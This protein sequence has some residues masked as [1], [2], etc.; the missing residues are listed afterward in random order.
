MM[1]HTI[2]GILRPA[3]PPKDNLSKEQRK[4]LKE[5]RSLENE[6]ILPADKGNATLMM[7]RDDYD[8]KMRGILSTATYKQLK[9]DPTATQEG[10]LSR[11]LKELEKKGEISGGLYHRLRPSVSQPPR[12]YGLPKT[13]KD[14]IPIRPIVCCIGAPSYQLS[15]HI[16]S[17]ISPLAGKTA[18]HVKNSRH[19]VQV[20]ADL[21]IE[22]DETLVSFDV[23]SLFTNVPVDEAVR[24]IRDRLR[25]DEALADRTTLST[26]RVADLLEMC[27]KSTYFSYGGEFFEQREGA[28][29]GSSVSAVVADLYMEFFEELALRTAPMKPRLWKRYVDDTCCIVKK[30]TVEELLTHVKNVRPSIRFTD[31]NVGK[32]NLFLFFCLFNAGIREPNPF[33]DDCASGEALTSCIQLVYTYNK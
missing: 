30:G 1:A 23:S 11:K 28:A 21:R 26:D 27:L 12:I 29:M 32:T 16:A 18:S 6:V 24:V 2:C 3:K 15:K 13:H 8:T 4:A 33:S 10:R 5:L 31:Q 17:L 9:K 22:E 7:T 19:F 25:Q 20:M 14:G